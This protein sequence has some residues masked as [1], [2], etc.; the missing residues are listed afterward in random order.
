VRQPQGL[1]RDSPQVDLAALFAERS[2]ELVRQGGT[3]ALLLPM[4]L[5]RSLAGGGVRRLFATDNALR[6]VEDWSEAPHAFDAAV[7]PSLVVATRADRASVRTPIVTAV[8]RKRLAITWRTAYAALALDHSPGAPWLLLPP[9]ARRVHARIANAGVPLGE[10]SLGAPTMGVKCGC[11]EAFLVR[12]ESLGIGET[13]VATSRGNVRIEADTLRPVLRGESVRR[14]RAEPSDEWILWTHG[15]DGRPVSKL[16]PAA[17]RW[18]ARWRGI[19]TARVMR[20]NGAVV[21]VSHRWRGRGPA[22]GGVGRCEPG[23]AGLR[24]AHRLTACPA[25]YLLRATLPRRHRCGGSGRAAQLAVDGVLA[26]RY[27]GAGTWRIPPLHGVD[28]RTNAGA[29]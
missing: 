10:S 23:T 8:H 29:T 7:Y 12:A 27:C 26:R 3:V 2:M 9:D 22:A 25:Q 28:G 18:L 15:R 6:V 4:K 16:A 1:A 21:A 11:N 13:I 19:L 14:W 24:P 17:G 5:W 20:G